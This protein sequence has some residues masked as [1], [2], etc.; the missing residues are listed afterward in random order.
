MTSTKST[1]IFALGML[2]TT[3]KATEGVWLDILLP[4]G[5]PAVSP[6]GLALRVRVMGMDSPVYQ[7]VIAHRTRIAQAEAIARRPGQTPPI[8]DGAKETANIISRIMTGWEGFEE[9]GSTVEN[10]KPIPFTQTVAE[11]MLLG[12][13]L[14]RDQIDRF[15]SNRA[16]FLLE[17]QQG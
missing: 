2:D 1:P 16:N 12:F 14:I 5:N 11:S 6:A 15:V 4:N 9:A 17:P 7:E 3:T 10:P 8:T 13:P